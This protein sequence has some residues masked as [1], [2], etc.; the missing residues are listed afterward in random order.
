MSGFADTH[1][2]G[3]YAVVFTSMRTEGD[4]GYEEAGNRIVELVSQSK[5]FL[6]AESIRGADGFGITVSYW[7]SMEN[8][9]AW[10]NNADH[11][12]AKQSGISTWY[13]EYRIR[14][15]RVEYDASFKK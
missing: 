5:G 6:G 11:A 10:K 13:D 1:G 9:E 3:Y 7:D 8:I 12:K 15:C 4:K 14:I 2:S